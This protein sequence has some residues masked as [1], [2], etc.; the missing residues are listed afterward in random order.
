M[1]SGEIT[2][3]F[4]R[5]TLIALL[6]LAITDAYM[7]RKGVK[8]DNTPRAAVFMLIGFLIMT[9][10][11]MYVGRAS[12]L[13]IVALILIYVNTVIRVKEDRKR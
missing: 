5:S 4:L 12:I 11:T 7:A 9:L 8:Y 10:V 3:G 6:L 1:L 2:P 13:F